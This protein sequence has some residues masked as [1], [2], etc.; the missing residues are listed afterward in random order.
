VTPQPPLP[1]P[2]P[3]PFQ[4]SGA[5]PRPIEGR[6]GLIK[7]THTVA[8]SLPAEQ[9]KLAAGNYWFTATSIEAGAYETKDEARAAIDAG[10][11]AAL[12]TNAAAWK[13]SLDA[14]NRQLDLIKARIVTVAD[15]KVAC[16]EI[17]LGL[18]QE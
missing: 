15:F 2:Y 14:L 1:N 9:R 17:A 3:N 4:S 16:E 8:G 11:K 18:E 13:A 6:F 10:N 7:F 5:A 12:G